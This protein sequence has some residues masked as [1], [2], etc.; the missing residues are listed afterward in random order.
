M[1]KV[2]IITVCRNA[3]ATIR[4]TIESVLQLC[5]D[6][7]EYVV[8]DGASTDGTCAILSE[9]EPRFNGRMKWISAPDKGI[10]DAMNKGLRLATGA[11]VN[12]Q[13]EGDMLIDIPF[14][15]LDFAKSCGCGIFACAVDTE[16][17]MQRSYLNF[18][19]RCR[20]TIQHQGAFYDRELVLQLNGY[21]DSYKILGDH[22]LNLRVLKSG[23]RVRISNQICAYHS[24]RGISSHGGAKIKAEMRRVVRENYGIMMMCVAWLENK[25]FGL[26]QFI[27]SLCGGLCHGSH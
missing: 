18:V 3:G 15:E 5:D 4:K 1:P 19:T 22:D 25:L 27:G 24:V 20:N 7:V 23:A 16:G 8:V 21:D 26:R 6:R 12:Y 11:W 2:S 13:N 14:A 9:Y 10:Y 17:G